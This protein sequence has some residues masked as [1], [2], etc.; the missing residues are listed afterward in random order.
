VS[1]RPPNNQRISSGFELAFE[2]ALSILLFFGIGW[3]LDR[4]L[5]TAPL[6]MIVGFLVGAVGNFFRLWYLY[7]GAMRT[8]EAERALAATGRGREQ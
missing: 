6:F 2:F 5:G 4:W 8:A 7:D 1:E 3:L